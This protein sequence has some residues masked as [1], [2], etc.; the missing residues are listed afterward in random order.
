MKA[1][2]HSDYIQSHTWHGNAALSNA[3]INGKIPYDNSAHVGDDCRQ[4]LCI[5]NCGQTAADRDMVTVLTAYKNSYTRHRP[6]QRYSGR[7][8]YTMY[9]LATIHVLQMTH[10]LTDRQ[11]T[12]RSDKNKTKKTQRKLCLDSAYKPI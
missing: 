3:T 5:Q 9:D 8:P 6:I 10:R 2:S 4:Q 11:A 1:I 7:L 12:K